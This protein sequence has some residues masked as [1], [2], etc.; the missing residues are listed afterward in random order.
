MIIATATIATD[1]GNSDHN[2]LTTKRVGVIVS[3]GFELLDALGPFEALKEVQERYYQK[4]NISQRTW[5]A[6][7]DS[8]IRC[9]KGTLE[10]KVV[11]ASFQNDSVTSSSG[12]SVTP[13][14]DLG[15]DPEATY[16]DWIVL[17]AGAL[18]STDPQAMGYLAKHH[19]NG[20]SILTVC[21][22]SQFTAS[23]GLLDG[24]EATSNS[25]FLERFR[26]AYP[27]V[28]WI[29]LVDNLDRR[30]VQSTDQ[31]ITTAGITAGIDGTLH[32]IEEW[33]GNDVAEATRQSFEWPLS[34]EQVE[35]EPQLT[36]ESTTCDACTN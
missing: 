9:S 1:H 15:Q 8:G 24:K 7:S 11:L 4:I 12:L 30:F 27:K 19:A 10:V 23:L 35:K 13:E 22:A 26:G 28:R 14:F 16:F 18:E 2:P 31:I 34:I 36:D 3:D 17:G 32:L 29:S 6:D 20:G 5:D 25:L 21:T 33:C